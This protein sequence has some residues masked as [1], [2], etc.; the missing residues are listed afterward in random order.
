MKKL[1][2]IIMTLL[3][4]LSLFACTPVDNTPTPDEKPNL[5]DVDI[6]I[7]GDGPVTDIIPDDWFG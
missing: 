4:S 7:S 2:C 1:L 6:G 3:L 5:G